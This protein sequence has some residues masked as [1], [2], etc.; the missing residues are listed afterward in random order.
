MVQSDTEVT[1][2]LL[3]TSVAQN[4]PQASFTQ[5][6]SQLLA[7]AYRLHV[8]IIF[9]FAVLETQILILQAWGEISQQSDVNM[10]IVGYSVC[11][12]VSMV[13]RFVWKNHVEATYR[14]N[15]RRRR[16]IRRCK[17]N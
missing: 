8:D 7:R 3:I 1:D 17:Y 6:F 14:R 11:I 9:I 15:S 16:C 13:M 10:H 2:L 5:I 4:I 12:I